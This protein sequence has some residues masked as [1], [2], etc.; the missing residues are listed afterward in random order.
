MNS[1]RVSHL[2]NKAKGAISPSAETAV[3]IHCI[4]MQN[5]NRT[6]DLRLRALSLVLLQKPSLHI[7]LA[8]V[9]IEHPRDA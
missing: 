2:L 7:M 8:V 5:H 3:N 1:P 6:R 4:Q 9:H